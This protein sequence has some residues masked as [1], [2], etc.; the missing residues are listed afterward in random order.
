[1]DMTFAKKIRELR[2]KKGWSV[3]DL[4]GKLF[5]EKTGK[6]MTAGY[7][8]K[9]EARGEIPSPEMIIR[10]AEFLGARPE[11]LIEIAKNAKAKEVSQVVQ[12]KYDDGLSLYRRSKK[13]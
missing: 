9:I 8:S 13:K 3:R 6:S 12:Q 7:V 11:D 2:N 10:L 5:N 4:A 1:M